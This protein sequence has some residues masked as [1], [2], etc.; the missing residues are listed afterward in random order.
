MRRFSG[1]GALVGGTQEKKP[2]SYIVE[3]NQTASFNPE[4]FFDRKEEFES[5]QG[6]GDWRN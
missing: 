1:V 5:E 6:E 2:N 4:E 3:P